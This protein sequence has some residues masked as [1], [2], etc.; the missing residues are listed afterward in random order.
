M[1]EPINVNEINLQ[2]DHIRFASNPSPQH[3]GGLIIS[4]SSNIGIGELTLIKNKDGNIVA[5]TE[6][7]DDNNDRSFIKKIFELLM[8]EIYVDG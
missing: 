5:L 8:D 7:M 6:A 2:I 4:W 3:D 1:P